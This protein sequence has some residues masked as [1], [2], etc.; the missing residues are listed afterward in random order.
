MWQ[1]LRVELHD[2]LELV[3]LP[4]LAAVLPWPWCFSVFRR[5]A[6]CE[7]LYRDACETALLQARKRGWGG[8]DERHWLWQRR[9]VTLVDHADHYLGLFRSDRWM[10][11]YLQVQ[12]SWPAVGHA[13]MLMTFHWGAGYWGLRHAAAHGLRPHAL[14]AS[15]NTASYQGRAVLSA[16]ARARN[17]NV[18]ATL[19]APV[20]D[21][22]RQLKQVLT[23]LRQKELL[24]GVMD[25]PAD[26]ALA[27]VGVQILGMSAR[28]PSGLFRLVS[29][30]QVPVTL[31]V[32]GIDTQT[33]MRSLHIRQVK[34]GMSMA[35]LVA[36]VFGDLEC[37]IA[38]SAP[39][40]HF[41]GISERFFVTPAM[42]CK[43]S[44]TDR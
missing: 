37:L 2:L 24:L 29:E 12:G 17:A 35:A 20:I 10:G 18:A 8:E 13:A 34:T 7:W 40:W 15:L 1:R 43:P 11:R 22:A 36:N 41:W 21:V 4:G 26:D 25:V 19:R 33:G 23:A 3:L 27:S 14:V 39:S 42:A 31:Y 30:H 6:R 5:V 16:Y 32:T 28:V 9:L 44:P 38:Q